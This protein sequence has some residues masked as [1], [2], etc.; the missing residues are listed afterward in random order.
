MQQIEKHLVTDFSILDLT[1]GY[2]HA[3]GSSVHVFGPFVLHLLEMHRIRT[4]TRRLQI[5]FL[6]PKVK[7]R[8]PVNCS[9]DE[10]KNWRSKNISLFNLE[11]VE[12]EGF[13]GEDHEFDF[14][15]VIF[16]CAPML[17]RMA[18]RTSNE[19]MTSNDQRT[20][21]QDVFKLYPFVECKLRQ[22]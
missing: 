1:I 21:I 3:M 22:Y 5:H 10:P 20:K 11:E 12:I 7:K 15:K 17:K 9:C 18:I 2:D 6:R 8:C 4:A 14:L 19:V 13:D 16:S